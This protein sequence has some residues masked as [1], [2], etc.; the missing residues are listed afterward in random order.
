MH[1]GRSWYPQ[2]NV[3]M[4][5]GAWQD[6]A[7][8]YGKAFRLAPGGFSFAAANQSLALYQLGRTKEAVREMR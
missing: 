2:G 4:A 6:A 1:L 3:R 8:F 7:D 5:Q